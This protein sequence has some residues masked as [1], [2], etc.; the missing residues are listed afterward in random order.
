MVALEA[1]ES[2]NGT[3]TDRGRGRGRALGIQLRQGQ[4]HGTS[5]AAL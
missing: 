3:N 5:K 4:E 2:D 1:A